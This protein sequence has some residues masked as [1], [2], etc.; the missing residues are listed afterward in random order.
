MDLI[1]RIGIPH[2]LHMDLHSTNPVLSKG[3][4][5]GHHFG[6]TFLFIFT[7]DLSIER[8]HIDLM[9]GI[10]KLYISVGMGTTI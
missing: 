9:F 6:I 4:D 2:F 10:S 1:K 7:I 5:G 3:G 8:K